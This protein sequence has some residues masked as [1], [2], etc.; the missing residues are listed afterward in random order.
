MVVSCGDWNRYS[1]DNEIKAHQ[2]REIKYISNHPRYSGLKR[3]EN[4]VSLL[5]L[6]KEFKLDTHLDTIC[7]PEFINDRENNYDKSDCVV[8]GWGKEKFDEKGPQNVL[9]QV[10]LPLLDN[11]QC[12]SLLQKTR[13]GGNFSLDESFL[14]AGGRRGADA[15]TGDGGGPLVCTDKKDFDRYA[16]F[17]KLFLKF[18]IHDFMTYI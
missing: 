16:L 10:E 6:K 13:L 14:C 17:T 11:A 8:M 18:H 5:H 2:E 7:L 3:I 4:D 9:K 15:C 1:D 12:Q